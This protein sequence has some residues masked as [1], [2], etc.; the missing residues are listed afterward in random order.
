MEATAEIEDCETELFQET[1]Q[2]SGEVTVSLEYV[3][4]GLKQMKHPAFQILTGRG[5]C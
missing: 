5:N 4:F 1:L 2:R 3:E